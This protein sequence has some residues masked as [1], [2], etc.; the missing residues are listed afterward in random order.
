VKLIYTLGTS[1]RPPEEFI[2]LVKALGVQAIV[3]VRRFPTS[4][5]VHFKRE[6]LKGLV[7]GEGIEYIYLG[8]ELGGFRSGGYRAFTTTPEFER[9]LDLLEEE[10]GNKLALILCAERLPWRCH[11]RFI[12]Q[13]LQGRGW[14]VRHV[15][16]EKR[17]WLAK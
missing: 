9:G 3:D 2:H 17:F 16:D 5:F 14:E 6:T 7:E 12:A 4:R 13:G 1:N 8:K 15:I 11:R 10:A